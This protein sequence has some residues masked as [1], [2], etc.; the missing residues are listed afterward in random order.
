MKNRNDKLADNLQYLWCDLRI[1]ISLILNKTN[2]SHEVKSDL[3]RR[4]LVRASELNRKL[5]K[6]EIEGYTYRSL[7]FEF[8]L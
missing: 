6:K 7:R 5:R 3:I 4:Y 8:N 2:Y 1:G